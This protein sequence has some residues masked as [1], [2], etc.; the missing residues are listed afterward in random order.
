KTMSNLPAKPED[1]V[2]SFIST[3][4]GPAGEFVRFNKEHK[5]V[6]TSDGEEIKTGTK[7]VCIF[8]QTQHGLI[9]FHE[10]GE[11]PTRHM[12]PMF[13]GYVPPARTDLGDTDKS[14][15]PKGLNGE[16]VDPWKS[17]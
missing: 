5:Y 8:D 17:Q 16:P 14:L 6:C 7:Y 3:Y 13:G 9:K 15:W 1:A 2:N 12:G 4:G 10:K 11:P